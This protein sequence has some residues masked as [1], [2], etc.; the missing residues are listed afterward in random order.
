MKTLF[1]LFSAIIFFSCQSTSKPG[2]TVKGQLKNQPAGTKVYLEELTYS[3]RNALDSAE[4]DSRGNFKIEEIILKNGLYQ[5]RMGSANGIF[6]VLDEKNSNVEL[7][8]DTSDITNYTYKVKGSAP[9]E[10]LRKFIVQTKNYGESFGRAMATYKQ[11]VNA[12]TPDSI[13]KKYENE[14]A[15]ADSTFRLY[16]KNVA[17]TASNPILAIFA[18]SNLDYERDSETYDKLAARMKVQQTSIPFVQSYVQM[19]DDQK[20][21]SQQNEMGA[22]FQ[23]GA[24]V[25]DIELQDMNGNIRKLSSLHGSVVL[26]D[27]W[28]SWCGPC[29]RENPSVVKAYESYKDKGFTVFSVSLDTNKDKWIEGIKKDQLMWPDHVSDLQGWKS[30]VCETFGVRAIPQNYLL[31]KEGKIIAS[32]L[33][34]EELIKTLE[35]IFQ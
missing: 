32:N 15:V 10:Q 25:P 11:N 12:E 5:L 35:G 27:F 16:A 33:R 30:S 4:L 2:L 1:L 8:A 6:L 22:K 23:T 14:L 17:D 34:G 29:R 13:V 3:T 9:S 26:L 31:D 21:R 24:A 20:S 7:T 18:I 28:A 19:V